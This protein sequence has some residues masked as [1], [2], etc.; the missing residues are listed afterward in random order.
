MGKLQLNFDRTT[1]IS[2]AKQE[3][4]VAIRGSERLLR[5]II[6]YFFRFNDDDIFSFERKFTL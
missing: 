4:A 3:I 1:G 2:N 5:K 6:D